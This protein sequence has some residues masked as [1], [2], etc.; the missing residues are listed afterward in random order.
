M[1]TDSMC[2]DS[3]CT[4][5]AFSG[6]TAPF[7]PRRFRASGCTAG[8]IGGPAGLRALAPDLDQARAASAPARLVAG[9]G[10]WGLHGRLISSLASWPGPGPGPGPGSSSAS[11][12][13]SA[14]P[15][16]S[17]ALSRGRPPPGPGPASAPRE[18]G[19][20]AG[21]W[22]P[23]PG[24]GCLGRRE[25]RRRPVPGPRVPP[26]P[27]CT[28]SGEPAGVAVGLQSFC[29]VWG[30]ACGPKRARGAVTGEASP[31][32]SRLAALPPPMYSF[33]PSHLHHLKT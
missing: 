22:L 32:W 9:G 21:G 26:G 29:L 30:E 7:A 27:V 10:P 1:S 20:A 12:L 6:F 31:D 8:P 18:S 14:S 23:G 17:S 33:I 2:D 5:S 24:A 13:S 11:A 4:Q 15:A 28:V 16:P 25:P 19:A 3:A